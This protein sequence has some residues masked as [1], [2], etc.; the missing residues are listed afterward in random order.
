MGG[1]AST[2]GV[3]GKCMVIFPGCSSEPQ[4]RRS[5]TLSRHYRTSLSVSGALHNA[6]GVDITLQRFRLKLTER[7]A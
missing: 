5:T 6:Y 1:G 3:G 7:S 4:M 2:T